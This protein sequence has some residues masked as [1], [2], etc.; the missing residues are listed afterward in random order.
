Y[1]I[2]GSAASQKLLNSAPWSTGKIIKKAGKH[3]AFLICSFIIGNTFLAYFIGVRELQAIIT[4]PPTTHLA[5]LMSMTVFSF[6]FYGV[7]AFFREQ[8]CTVVCPYGRLQG[9]LLDS[10]SMIVAYDYKRG[11]PRTKFSKKAELA[12]GDCVDCFQCVKVCPTGIDIRNGTQMECIGCTACIDACDNIMQKI[13]R[14]MGLIRYASENAILKNEPLRYSARMKFYT[15]IIGCLLVT[16]SFLL[17]T[18]KDID[19]TI[20]RTPGMMYQQRAGDSVSNLYNIR[21][22]N[23]TA[24]NIPLT[25]KLE[26]LSGNI[27]TI[28][29]N[30]SLNIKKEEEGGGSFF[31]VLPASA[32]FT[33]KTILK[34]GL[35]RGNEQIDVINTIFMS[36]GY[37]LIDK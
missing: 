13:N 29:G 30:L 25:L 5:G 22:A 7:Y 27:E 17:I 31:V 24:F 19:A 14:P 4:S 16:L 21:I 3:F 33:N 36:P 9:V 28:G 2:E 11:E 1:M 26:N 32:L 15:A 23:K 8:V 37:T 35:Y 10:N 34:I 20:I 6:V 12:H 18:R